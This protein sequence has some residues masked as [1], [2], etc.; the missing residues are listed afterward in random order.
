LI[1]NLAA[2]AGMEMENMTRGHG[3]QFLDIG[4]RLERAINITTLIQSDLSI[5]TK[6][7]SALEPILEIADSVMTYRRRYFAQP[8]WPTA[9]DLLLADE[10]NPRSLTFQVNALANHIAKLPSK[11][12]RRDLRQI[13]VLRGLLQNADLPALAE[14]QLNARD[15]SL[16]ALLDRIAT[17]LRGVSNFIN[18]QYFSHAE[19]RVS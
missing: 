14:A 8:Q 19:T 16:T 4:R 11:T 18:H 7:L 5:E 15:S 13:D 3:W 2:F 6:G 17:E 9:L 12:N 10:G 1:A